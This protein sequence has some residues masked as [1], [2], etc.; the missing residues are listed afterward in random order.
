M[1]DSEDAGADGCRRKRQ[2][3]LRNPTEIQWWMLGSHALNIQSN[4]AH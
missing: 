3:V 4:W 1:Q 2:V